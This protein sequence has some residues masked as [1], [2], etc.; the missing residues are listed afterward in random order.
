MPLPKCVVWYKNGRTLDR[1]PLIHIRR[2]IAM[3]M[4][5]MDHR[6]YDYDQW[7]DSNRGMSPKEREILNRVLHKLDR[8]TDT[9]P[10][11]IKRMEREARRE[12]LAELAE[13]LEGLE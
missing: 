13:E 10:G 3:A 7:H 12:Y 11:Y 5:M 1:Q 4:R 6:A 2:E 8:I 9:V